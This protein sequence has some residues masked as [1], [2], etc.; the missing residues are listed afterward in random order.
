MI[1]VAFTY[2]FIPGIDEQA[3][4]QLAKRATAM[5]LTAPGF[6]EFR[7][8]RN[9]VG[10]PHV[11]RTSVWESLGHWASLA[12]QPEFQAIRVDRNAQPPI[13]AGSSDFSE[14]GKARLTMPNQTTVLTCPK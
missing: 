4:T 6:L 9:M 7:A 2:D 13:P 11:R 3:Y 12:Q 5:M 8:H 1:E 10:T 14:N